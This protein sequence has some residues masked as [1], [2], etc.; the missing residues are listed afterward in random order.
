MCQVKED[1]FKTLRL[2]TNWVGISQLRWQKMT[3]T[4]WKRHIKFLRARTSWILTCDDADVLGRCVEQYL[5]WQRSAYRYGISTAT[6]EDPRGG[7]QRDKRAEKF[8]RWMLRK[9]GFDCRTR[10]RNGVTRC[11]R[12]GVT[13][14]NTRYRAKLERLKFQ[15][16]HEFRRLRVMSESFQWFQLVP[17]TA[18]KRW[19]YSAFF[20]CKRRI[21]PRSYALDRTKLHAVMDHTEVFSTHR[22]F[23]LHQTN[24]Q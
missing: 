8:S 10:N 9:R 14:V 18:I 4:C 15:L 24:S 12:R 13:S 1:F 19:Y 23:D 3:A 17:V 11:Q 22:L 6:Q 21:R 2:L 5:Q 20:C 16:A 7:R